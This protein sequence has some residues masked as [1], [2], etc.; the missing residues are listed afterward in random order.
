M[1]ETIPAAR[2]R[3]LRLLYAWR[4]PRAPFTLADAAVFAL[5]IGALSLIALGG[6]QTLTPLPVQG[7]AITLN[8]LALPGYA[9]RTTLRMFAAMSVSVLC[10][11]VFGFWAAKSRRAEMV[12]IPLVDVMQSVPVLAFQALTLAFF[13]GLFPGRTLGAELAAVFLVFTSQAWNMVFSFYHSC[14]TVPRELTELSD[15][16]R[17]G[18]WRR[19]WALEAPYAA[20]A[21]IWNAMISMSGA[22]FFVVANEAFDVGAT[23]IA[24]P[25]VGS[26]V[27]TAIDRKDLPA[28][29]WALLTMAAVIAV[30][31]QLIFRPLVAWSDKFR[32]GEGVARTSVARSWAL[33]FMRRATVM[34]SVLKPT[35]SLLSSVS[36][37]RLGRPITVT[38]PLA[39]A[40]T[41]RRSDYVWYA[42]LGLVALAAAWRA[43]TYI[44]ASIP[45]PEVFAVVGLGAI[46]LGRVMLLVVVAS[47]VWVP[48]G[49]WI[50]LRP[51]WTAAVQPFLQFA[52]AFPNNLFFPLAAVAIIHFGL[53]PD[54]W[55]T[56]LIIMGTQ[57]YILFNVVAG[58]AAFPGDLLEAAASMRLKGW[59]WWRRVIL[60]GIFPA[61]VTGAITAVGGSWNA[62]VVAEV[63]DWGSSRIRAHGLGAYIADAN[64]AADL[65]RV[66][67]GTVVM[68]VY[69]VLLNRLFWEPVFAWGARRLRSE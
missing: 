45:W 15:S 10:T 22:W 5:V 53:L 25:G 42:A 48:V 69:V 2:A 47:L 68:V 27:Q 41:G 49:V 43:T 63:I 6:R 1:T 66:V 3:P 37:I 56:P 17:L 62:S 50:G 54:I 60:P 35:A 24:L 39:R 28:I 34:R 11:F 59:S 46:T 38:P 36:S 7:D 61:Y 9:L 4:V 57:W 44:A 64:H 32:W 20:P 18:A 30:Y 31:D 67:L 26:Y 29:G 23:H 16:L 55:L 14:R 12:I 58:A 13:L 65:P 21:L 52:A 40:L 19:L 51:R 33:D 8:P